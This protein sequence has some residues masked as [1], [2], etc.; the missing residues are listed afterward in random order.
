MSKPIKTSRLRAC[1]GVLVTAGALLVAMPA[2]A[3]AAT[4]TPNNNASGTNSLSADVAAIDAAGGSNTI[5]LPTG[6]ISPSST[7][8]F[9]STGTTTIIGSTA[10]QSTLTATNV[11]PFPSDFID[12]NDGNVTFEHVSINNGGDSTTGIPS[13]NV[14][15]NGATAAGPTLTIEDSNVNGSSGPALELENGTATFEDSTINDGAYDASIIDQNVVNLDNSTLAYNSGGV[16]DTGGTLN[17]TNSILTNNAGGN[18]LAPISEFGGV[19]DHSIISDTTCGTAAGNAGLAASSGSNPLN[20]GGYLPIFPLKTGSAAIGAGDPA[21]CPATDERGV[22]TNSPC[23]LG[24]AAYTPPVITAPTATV[25]AAD[26]SSHGS[27]NVSYTESAT[28]ADPNGNNIGDTITN[29]CTPASGASFPD[30]ST[31]VTC[32]ASDSYGRTSKKTF[33]VDVLTPPVFQNVPANITTSNPVVTYTAP[34]ATNS[35]GASLPVSCNPASGSTFSSGLTTVTCS[36]TDQ[37]G[38]TGT[39]TFT[40]TVQAATPPTITVPANIYVAATSAAGGAPVSYTVTAQDSHGNALTPSCSPTSGSTFPNG[41]TTVTCSATDSSNNTSTKTFTVTVNPWLIVTDEPSFEAA[42]ATANGDTGPN[43][44]SLAAGIYSPTATL[45]FTNTTGTLTIQGPGTPG[46][47]NEVTL[48]GGANANYPADMFDVNA[49]ASVTFSDV[50]IVTGGGQ[51]GYPAINDSGNVDIEYSS[52]SGSNGYGLDVQSGATATVR[53]STIGDGLDAGIVDAGT[54][55]LFNATVY[56]NTGEG[57]YNV[58]GTLNLTNSIVGDNSG[59]DCAVHATSSDHSLDSDGSCGVGALSHMNPKLGALSNN[60]GSTPAFPVQP[61][62][63]A[64]GAGDPATCTSVDQQFTPRANPCT[65]GAVEFAATTPT[66][67]VPSNITTPATGTT[68]AVVSY[69]ATAHGA[70]SPVISFSCRPVSGATFPIGTTTVTC[71]ATDANGG[72]A[73]ASFSVTVTPLNQTIT[74][75]TAPSGVVVGGPSYTPTA[76][77]SSGLTVAIT[78]DSTSTGCS[79]S[80]GV[81][82]FSHVGTCVIDFNQAGN[83]TYNAAP[84]VQQS[85]TIGKGSQTVSFT[86]TAPTSETVGGPTYTPTASASSG[87]TPVITLDSTSTGCTIS[88]GVVSFTSTG[89]CLIDANQ[90]GNGD[91][92][93]ATQ[94]QQSIPVGLQSQSITITSTA[95]SGVVVGGSSYTPTATAS[96]GLTVAITLDGSSTGC[97]LTSGVV[98]FPHAGTCVIDFNQPGNGT[99]AAAAQKQQSI[100]IGKASQTVSFTSTAP[101]SETVGGPT[102]TPTASAS[103]GLTPVITLDASSTGCSISSGVVS[104]TGAGTCLIDANQPGNGD[105]NAATQVQQSIP[106]GL[107]SQSITITSTAPTG[108]V[109]GGSSYTPTA[110]A[111]SGLTVAITLD[112]TSTGCSL[113]GGV[114]SFPHAGTCV[115]DFNQPGNGTYAA[116]AQKQQS[117]TIG[118][119]SQTVSFTSTAPT[120]ETVGGPTYTPTASASS[121]LTPV[122]TLDASSTGCSISSGVVSFTSTG[123]CKIDANQPGNGDYNAAT[124]VQQSIAVGLQSQTITITSTAPTSETVGGPT[125]TPTAT[126]SSGLTVAITL[127]SSSTGCTLASGVVSFTAAGTCVI[128]FNQ[129]GN[130]TYAAA[131]QKQQSIP[132]GLQSQT[133]TITST[134]PTGVVVGGSSYT[135]T[136]TASS[137]LTVAITLDST[138]TGCSLSG[139]VV[140]FP[141]AGTCVIDFNQPGNGT[142]AAAAQ[143]QQ[144]ITIGKASQ[145]VSFTSTAPTSETVGGPTYT[146]TA[147]ASSGLTPVITLDASS[148]GCSISSGV[149]SFTSTG[150]CKIDAN[151]PGNGDYNAATQVQQSIAVGLQSQT[152]TITSTAPTSETVGGPTYTPTATASSGLTVAITL[153]S[154]STGCTLASGV[155]SFTAAGTCVIDFNQAGNGTYAAAPQKQ[156]SIPVGLQSQTITITSTAPTGVVVGGSSYTPTATASSGLTVAITLDGSSTGCVL[157]SGVVSFPHA[158]TCVIDFN[159]AGNGTYAAAAQKQQSITI[160]K[161]SQTITITS[162]APTSA[163][164]GGA[165]YTPT[166]T[167]SSGLAVAITLDSSSTGCTLAS[168]VVSFTAAGTCVIDFNQAGNTDYTTAPQKQQSIPVGLQSQS[169]TITSTAPTGVVVGGSSYTPAATAS[170]GLT[171]AITLDSTSTGCVLTSGVVSFPHAGTCVIDFNQAGN[172]TYAAAAQKQQSITI[173]K[174]SQTITI[175]STAPTSATVG[176]ASYTPT[177]TA[178]SGLAVAITLDSS[179]TGC[180][181]ASGV[182][183][184]TAVGTCVIDFNQAG[185]S[186]YTTA[187]QKQQSIPVTAATKTPQT[188]T[189]TSTAPSGVVVGSSS[190]TPTAT[191]S[192]GLTVAITLDS[193]STGCALTSGVVSFPHA[194]TCVIDFNQPGNGTYA[195]AAQKQQSITIGKASQT[196]SFTSTAPTSATVGGAKYTPTA[197]ATSGLAVAITV[198]SSSSSICSISSGVV[199]F[200]AAGTCTLDANQAGNGDYNAAAQ[201]QQKVTV[202]KGSQTITFTSTAPTSATIGSTYTPTATASSGLA[203]TITI[204]STSLQPS[205]RSPQGS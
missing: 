15:Q 108:V 123:T 204:D 156:Q 168:G 120:S 67:T 18:C 161:A 59:P 92:N 137:G 91:Y 61:G 50:S 192:S 30:G 200:N 34:T 122:I 124:Q 147:S 40:V 72:T 125:Y 178:S 126:A 129:A 195:A 165:S 98:S 48:N 111:S 96:S 68:G 8:V 113:S 198:D 87:L 158:G 136:A 179:S 78:L 94:V 10:A 160:G 148:T 138:S 65:I 104:F 170:S 116:A 39:A 89:T 75:S 52:I 107:Q 199:S 164:V 133:I 184:F 69:T 57:I 203:V 106:V 86:S 135:P 62:S 146:P 64:I 70:K 79:L 128:D 17:L 44:L 140:S 105:Y 144:S 149:V 74:P 22:A 5:D 114:V 163:T 151:Q 93:A 33:T 7:L 193:T 26:A 19:V 27:A 56:G 1:L 51:G 25:Y 21:A 77:A 60:D 58:G 53:N 110:T 63:P 32:T 166:A 41:T 29:S 4:Y 172:G 127:D 84:Q 118:K 175:T 43:V 171:V 100:T 181:L 131:P 205:A 66:I 80:G 13:I 103:S 85:I 99:Y 142:Y 109:V 186:D 42:I 36:A 88:S 90:P 153:D 9:S 49:G 28:Y 130:G 55:S 101:T 180:T 155:V 197:T 188:I 117:I 81:V 159:Q 202:G 183:S 145:T 119:A 37:A 6:N 47:A 189:I 143:K 46:Q 35:L 194:G 31:T 14:G 24:A 190:Y 20:D 102:Y 23:D 73:T 112:S 177:A 157:T 16:D 141:H 187:A 162:T 182:V 150:T 82:S 134:A 121:G 176:G 45:A 2:I 38:T 173:G 11:T 167:A 12:I 132:V 115:I 185:N 152:I 3:S 97:V 139:G 169:I 201:V 54:A 71:N 154:S 83:A 174:A 95:P 196:V 76:T 191:A